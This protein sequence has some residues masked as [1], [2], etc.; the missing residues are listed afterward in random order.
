VGLEPWKAARVSQT[1]STMAA[2]GRR[3]QRP[4]CEPSLPLAPRTR[5]AELGPLG[6][7][8]SVAYDINDASQVVGSARTVAGAE[9]AFIWTESRGMEDLDP[10]ADDWNSIAMGV[11]QTG[12]VVGVRDTPLGT[13]AFIWTRTRGLRILGSLSEESE[14]FAYGINTHRRIVGSN[15]NTADGSQNAVVWILENGIKP[16]PLP[17]STLP[18]PS[19]LQT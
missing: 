1:R 13:R 6:G 4:Q 9:H 3:K 16:Q 11:S 19:K 15:F 17:G 18:L 2:S 7:I 14:S 5:E 10:L 12:E 8:E